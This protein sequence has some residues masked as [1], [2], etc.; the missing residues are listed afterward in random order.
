M[1]PV[2]FLLRDWT[3]EEIQRGEMFQLTLKERVT[4]LGITALPT[5]SRAKETRT[6]SQQSCLTLLLT[7]G[8]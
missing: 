3:V 1:L 8:K 5:P 7:H 2:V 6:I 4:Q